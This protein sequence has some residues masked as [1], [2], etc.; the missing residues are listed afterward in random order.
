MYEPLSLAEARK[1]RSVR[2]VFGPSPR[3]RTRPLLLEILRFRV[4]QPCGGR[5][6][7]AG[8]VLDELGRAEACA[9]A[10]DV[11]TQP[12]E[13]TREVPGCNLLVELRALAAQGL[14]E[15]ARDHRTD[16]VRGKVTE[17][18]G[19]PVHVL[20]ATLGE[21]PELRSEEHTPEL[22]SRA[23]LVCRLLLEKK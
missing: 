5:E 1:Q 23:N 20:Q 19:S 7:P 6:R 9:V 16:R 12:F 10:V 3:P 14:V 22:Q 21:R 13:Q 17:R 15:L 8:G 2:S 11:L 4:P 18:A